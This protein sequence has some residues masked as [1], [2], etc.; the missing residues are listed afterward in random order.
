LSDGHGA[1]ET[2]L[3]T[4]RHCGSATEPDGVHHTLIEDRRQNATVSD[5]GEALKALG[6][7]KSRTHAPRALRLEV[8]VKALGIVL[9]T[10]KAA[11]IVLEF[12][13]GDVALARRASPCYCLCPSYTHRS[14]TVN[15]NQPL[16]ISVSP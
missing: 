9:A 2:H 10:Y 13:R 8:E 3:E 6:D 7:S 12:H 5:A 16:T 11:L 14:Q 1:Q 15:W 4:G